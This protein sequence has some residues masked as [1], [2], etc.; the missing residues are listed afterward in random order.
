MPIL[1]VLKSPRVNLIMEGKITSED[2]KRYD[3]IFHNQML[4]T[5]NQKGNYTIIPLLQECNIAVIEEVTQKEVDEQTAR[6]KKMQ[7]EAEKRG[8]AGP[9]ILQPA[10]FMGFPGGKGGKG[11]G[12]N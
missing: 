6:A 7:E 9:G 5:K 3:E 4:M 10:S 11:R 2:E 12:E 1:I 8:Q